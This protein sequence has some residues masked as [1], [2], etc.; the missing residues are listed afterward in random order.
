MST[1]Q[2]APLAELIDRQAAGHALEQPFYRDQALFQQ[3]LELVL[4]RQWLLVDHVA[5]IPEVGDY[6]LFEVGDDSIIVV[7]GRE[8]QVHAHFN[9]CRHRGSRV[10]LAPSG[11]V[12]TLVCPYHAWAYDLDG[13][14]K[15]ARLMPE[16]FAPEEHGLEPCHVR[17]FEGL[18]FV[19]LSREAPPDFESAYKP[20]RAFMAIH[21]LDKAKIAHK[22]SYP[23]LGNW[24]LVVENFFECYHCSPSHPE[25][26]AVH[27]KQK[28]LAFGAGPGSGPEDAVEAFQ[29]E[30][31]AWE[32][33]ARALGHPTGLLHDDE[34]SQHLREASR[35]PIRPGFLSETSDG[36]PASRLMG[37]FRDYDGGQ[38]SCSFNPLSSILMTNDCAVMFRFTPMTPTETD[39]EVTWLV[40]PDAEEGKDYDTAG[41]T[42]LWDVTTR[43]DAE[44]IENNHR[45][46]MSSRY[47]PGPY[48]TQEAATDRFVRWYLSRLRD[49]LN[50]T[51]STS[52]QGGKAATG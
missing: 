17:V 25:F 2:A 24:K 1:S 40:H 45:G 21:E 27:S 32:E 23:T 12:R 8:G 6:F 41:L 37:R 30:L 43:Q 49:G 36:T 4:S 42:W 50:R 15:A 18:I 52:T 13:S 7:R 5:R 20:F 33:R 39:V 28:R 14:L 38:T 47:R 48:S 46:V 31:E 3:D 19:C 29:Q 34:A 26:C 22:A 35:L 51:A 10:C 9:V 44:I 16:G 11:R